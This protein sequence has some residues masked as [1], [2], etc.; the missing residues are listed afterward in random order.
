MFFHCV[1]YV[2]LTLHKMACSWSPD[3]KRYVTASSDRKI[4]VWDSENGNLRATI[5][6]HIDSVCSIAWLP[7]NNNFLSGGIDNHI[8]MWDVRGEQVRF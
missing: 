5:T 7:N 8:I 4:K 6:G 1:Q 3:S 2:V